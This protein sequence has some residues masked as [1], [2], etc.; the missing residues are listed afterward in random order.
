MHVCHGLLLL[1]VHESVDG[2]VLNPVDRSV[3]TNYSMY[4]EVLVSSLVSILSR[5]RPHVSPIQSWL[6]PCSGGRL[7]E[8]DAHHKT[9]MY[10]DN[11]SHPTCIYTQLYSSSLQC[12]IIDC[13]K[14]LSIIQADAADGCR[15]LWLLTAHLQ[16]CM[17]LRSNTLRHTFPQ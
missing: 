9:W 15:G 8:T 13:E 17:P 14:P 5:T 1:F 3:V 11:T 12:M 2:V 4:A 16:V 6:Q 7:H 10:T